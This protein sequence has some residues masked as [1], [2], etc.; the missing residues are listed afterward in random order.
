MGNGKNSYSGVTVLAGA[1]STSSDM[2]LKYNIQDLLNR[3]VTNLFNTNNGY[4]RSFNWIES[5]E[6]SY[7]FIA[8]ELLEYCPE[9]VNYDSETN[10]YSVNYNIAFSKIIGAMF[11]KIKELENRLK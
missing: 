6:P 3:D 11:K 4:I 10:I 9:A 1:F 5:G 8:Q 2:R 7:G